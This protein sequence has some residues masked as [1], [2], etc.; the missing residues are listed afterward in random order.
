MIV[1][2][3]WKT[4]P[5]MALLLLAGL[6]VISSEVYE[7]GRVDGASVMQ[8]FWR[9][10]LPLLKPSIVVALLFRT[11]DAFRAFDIFFVIAGSALQSM[12]LYAYNNIIVSAINFPL[13]TAAAV[14]IF[15]GTII[16]SVIYVRGFGAQIVS[17]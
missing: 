7:A 3:V 2:D 15:I 13:G 4:A 5:Y 16:I 1:T 6:Q 14:C 10:T 8:R 17:A 11:L 9:I 12:S